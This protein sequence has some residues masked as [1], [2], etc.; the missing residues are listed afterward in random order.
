[1]S[2]KLIFILCISRPLLGCDVRW[3]G[4]DCQDNCRCSYES[5]YKRDSVVSHCEDDRKLDARALS[6][7]PQD[8]VRNKNGERLNMSQTNFTKSLNTCPVKES[9][10]LMCCSNITNR[11]TDNGTTKPDLAYTFQVD[12]S[13]KVISVCFILIR[14]KTDKAKLML[15]V[16]ETNDRELD[17]ALTSDTDEMKVY[18]Q[19][20][21]IIQF[22]IGKINPPFCKVTGVTLAGSFEKFRVGKKDAQVFTLKICDLSGKCLD[23]NENLKIRMTLIVFVFHSTFMAF[24]YFLTAWRRRNQLIANLEQLMVAIQ[25]Q[26]APAG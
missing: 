18:I 7:F 8:V 23:W 5:Q 17:L 14:E 11:S 24:L 16:T 10:E 19:P 9:V 2:W 1:M 15:T 4:S 13:G 25:Q 22:S 20:G 26:A 3:F 21:Y 12:Q 6:R